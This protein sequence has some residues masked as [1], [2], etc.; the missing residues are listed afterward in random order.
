MKRQV[1]QA[2]TTGIAAALL[3]GSVGIASAVDQVRAQ[4]RDR[5]KDNSCE[6]TAVK[7]ETRDQ[8]RDRLRDGDCEPV[9]TKEQTR[10]Q[11]RDRLKDGSGQA[12][13]TQATVR[14]RARTQDRKRTSG[15][16]QAVVST[17]QARD[18]DRDR[19]T[20]ARRAAHRDE[21]PGARPRS[22]QGRQLRRAAGPD[23]GTSATAHAQ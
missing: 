23:P 12:T 11:D 1:K 8:D 15:D 14:T 18:R 22:S 6:V 13:V 19:K 17:T 2:I 21:G 5:L 4:D 20:E 16:D 9:A 7:L 10:Q 3:L